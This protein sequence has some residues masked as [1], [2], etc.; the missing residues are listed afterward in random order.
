[1]ASMDETTNILIHT[2]PSHTAKVF[3]YLLRCCAYVRR[4]QGMFT[5]SKAMGHVSMCVHYPEHGG[6]RALSITS[7]AVCKLTHIAYFNKWER[8][9]CVCGSTLR[10][11]SFVWLAAADLFEQC[12]FVFI[13]HSPIGWRACWA[14]SLMEWALVLIIGGESGFIIQICRITTLAGLNDANWYWIPSLNYIAFHSKNAR[15]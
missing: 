14:E 10:S 15:N 1:M 7:P 2:A 6:R 13:I 9:I 8:A 3:A 4:T 11:F 5:G 12:C